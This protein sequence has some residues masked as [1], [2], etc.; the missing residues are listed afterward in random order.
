[1]SAPFDN[2]DL[3]AWSTSCQSHQLLIALTSRNVWKRSVV[4][5]AALN[6][7][8]VAQAHLGSL[9]KI[10]RV[11]RVGI[12]VVTCGDVREHPRVADGASGLFQ[13]IF[14]AEMKS[15]RSVY[16]IASLP[17]EAPVELDVIFEIDG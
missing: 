7:L 4:C 2:G 16:G 5:V 13:E 11:V 15:C 10:T 1:M 8:A 17:L 9:D 12:F 6:A 14:G 3:H